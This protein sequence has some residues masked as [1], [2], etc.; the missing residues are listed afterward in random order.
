[1]ANSES[2]TSTDALRRAIETVGSQAVLV[3]RLES[4]GLE[5]GQSHVSMWLKRGNVPAKYCRPI[6]K[7]TKGKVSR[8]DLLPHDWRFIWPE[9][10]RKFKQPA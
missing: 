1:M 4:Q 6:E 2:K 10:A 9:L 5:V 7:A 8:C 3:R